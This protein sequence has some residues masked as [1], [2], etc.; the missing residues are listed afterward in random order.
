MPDQPDHPGNPPPPPQFPFRPPVR[1]FAPMQAPFQPDVV[2]ANVPV[3]T[4]STWAPTPMST[5]QG[6]VRSPVITEQSTV[7]VPSKVP[8]SSNHSSL[9]PTVRYTPQKRP[10]DT[11]HKK[12]PPTKSQALT[13][14][15][16]VSSSSWQVPVQI[17]L[18]TPELPILEDDAESL[19]STL[20]ADDEEIF[21]VWEN[22][23][24]D[25]CAPVLL[26]ACSCFLNAIEYEPMCQLGNT[27]WFLKPLRELESDEFCVYDVI[28][29]SQ[30]IEKSLD[31]LTAAEVKANPKLI[32]TAVEKEL[33]SFV[34]HKC[35]VPIK[36]GKLGNVL[37]SRW[38]FKWKVIDGVRTV[39]ARLVVHGFKDHAAPTLVTFA[40]TTTR[41]GQR[42]INSVAAQNQWELISADVG[43]AFLQGLTFQQLA[44]LTGEPLREVGFIPPRGYEHFFQALPGLENFSVALWDLHMIKPIYGLCDAPRAWRKRLDQILITLHSRSLRADSAIY[45]WYRD[46]SLVAIASTHV[47]DLKIAGEKKF[48]QALLKSLEEVLGPLK[49]KS[50]FNSSFEHCG[51]MHLQDSSFTVTIHQDHY[52]AQLRPAD[53]SE[54]DVSRPL[55]LLN[56]VQTAVYLSLLGALSWLSQTRS[57]IMIYVQ[58][59]QR[60]AKSP[61]VEHLLR[62]NKITKWV[63]R[64][65]CSIRYELLQSPVK[66]CAISDSAFRKEDK[67]GLA[68]RGAVVCI[69]EQSCALPSTPGGK[70]HA[71][72]FYSRKQ[73]RICRSTYSAE[74]H[75]LIDA[76]ETARL[77]TYAFTE[78]LT[79]QPI[80]PSSMIIRDEQGLLC[81]DIEACIDAR[82]IFDS[83]VP[84][85]T[86]APTEGSLI[87]VLMQLKELLRCGTLRKLWWVN[88]HD[89]LADALTKGCVARAAIISAFRLG[90]WKLQHECF[91]HTEAVTV[92]VKSSLQDVQEH[93]AE[94]DG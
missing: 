53:V 84:A 88:T 89:Q 48:V 26:S 60:D 81:F 71:I 2:P 73:R 33:G 87:F 6:S 63:R 65:P 49:V 72:E 39:K 25:Y 58:S 79:V 36:K 1:P 19:A 8:V 74:L 57:D 14:S 16:S 17:P 45:V 11:T 44:E 32:T 4:G 59:L 92:K 91:S 30:V 15:T 50:A 9:A 69:C 94:R 78:I 75:G 43:T 90:T 55:V 37:T 7:P 27:C 5:R 67:S 86:K 51:I 82:S 41:W 42:I 83:L 22:I 56:A 77:I 64:K 10:V 28:A 20:R 66:T 68:M 62:L 54:I 52:C 12:G 29:N 47:D 85:D 40:N 13:P 3:P 70:F 35:F 34:T 93:L 80:S 24:D 23:E 76:V 21:A 46:D 31:E 61:R 38:L 18:H